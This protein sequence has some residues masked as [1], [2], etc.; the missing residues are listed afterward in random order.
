[1]VM[2]DSAD[3]IVGF[4]CQLLKGKNKRSS[5]KH[6]TLFLI[7]KKPSDIRNLECTENSFLSVFPVFEALF[8]IIFG[9]DGNKFRID[10]VVQSYQRKACTKLV[11]V[12]QECRSRV[13]RHG[14]CS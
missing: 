10:V 7:F 13:T 1:M 12:F 4:R 9:A 5:G 3:V 11:P 2:A 8:F 6:I 14:N